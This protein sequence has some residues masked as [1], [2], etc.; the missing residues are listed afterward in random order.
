[1]IQTPIFW[2]FGVSAVCGGT[3]IFPTQISEQTGRNVVENIDFSIE[4]EFER[5]VSE[6]RSN[7]I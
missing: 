4:S 1:M 6:V 5:I 7:N 2:N 3:D